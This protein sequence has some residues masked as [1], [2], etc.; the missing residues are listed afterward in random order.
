[1]TCAS[2]SRAAKLGL[3]KARE[4]IEMHKELKALVKELE[5]QGFVTWTRK[6]GHLAIY[7]DGVYVATFAGTPSDFRGWKNGIA[8]CRRKGFIWPAPS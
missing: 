7:K 3:H 4:V 5:K 2:A 8:A 1:L 6:N